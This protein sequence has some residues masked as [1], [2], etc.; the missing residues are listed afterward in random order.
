MTEKKRGDFPAANG[1][2]MAA[3]W[4]KGLHD[5][6]LAWVINLLSVL[7]PGPLTDGRRGFEHASSWQCGFHVRVPC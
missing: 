6:C 5:E 7:D 4:T 3:D 1:T 2:R